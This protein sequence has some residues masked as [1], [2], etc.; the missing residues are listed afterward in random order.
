MPCLIAEQL[1]VQFFLL[2]Q[3]Q[4]RVYD[5]FLDS[6]LLGSGRWAHIPVRDP[7]ASPVHAR[8]K[9]IDK[10]FVLYDML[11]GSGLYVNNR[12]LLRPRGL[13]HGDEIR[14]GR[15]VYTFLGK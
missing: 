8:I 14:I 7:L 15:I 10:R 13:K 11:S 9:K 2:S 4:K 5:L 3:P 12:K 6:T 1:C